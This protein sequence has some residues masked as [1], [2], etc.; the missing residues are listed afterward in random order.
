MKAVDV[1]G[2]STRLTAYD[3]L[4]MLIEVFFLLLPPYLILWIDIDALGSR[5]TRHQLCLPLLWH[6]EGTS[7]MS[8]TSHSTHS[9]FH[10]GLIRMALGGLGV[11]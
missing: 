2:P 4:V 3:I 5:V 11:V 1:R 9:P 8:F 6:V 7:T 10:A